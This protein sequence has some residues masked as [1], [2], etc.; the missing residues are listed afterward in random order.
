[1]LRQIDLASV[2]NAPDDAAAWRS[3]ACE[4]RCPAAATFLVLLGTALDLGELQS[5]EAER[6]RARASSQ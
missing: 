4:W 6:M 2:I 1:M 3:T 5:R